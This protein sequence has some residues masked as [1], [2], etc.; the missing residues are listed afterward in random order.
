MKNETMEIIE[1]LTSLLNSRKD[2]I[3]KLP[4]IGKREILKR[5]FLIIG[6]AIGS[7]V[8]K[9]EVQKLVNKMQ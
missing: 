7:R 1:F 8:S 2:E 9:K 3:K 5:N 6:L 4:D